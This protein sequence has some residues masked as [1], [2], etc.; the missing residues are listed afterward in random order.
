MNTIQI[1][2]F[3]F[4]K[5]YSLLILVFLSGCASIQS[6]P[7]SVATPTPILT[8]EQRMAAA[9]EA[10]Q[11]GNV[12]QAL[13]EY[14]KIIEKDNLHGKANYNLTI[15]HMEMAL[16]GMEFLG[17]FVNEGGDARDAKKAFDN[18]VNEAEIFTGIVSRYVVE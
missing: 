8:T 7:V 16:K 9:R 12:E 5:M 11:E 1:S 15:V 2:R 10:Y 17:Q 18:I 14:Q 13:A 3:H 4:F 6:E